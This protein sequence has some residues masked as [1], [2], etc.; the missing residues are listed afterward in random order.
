[1]IYC[2]S[3]FNYYWTE[4]YILSYFL[5]SIFYLF[6]MTPSI[7]YVITTHCPCPHGFSHT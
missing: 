2:I 4:E 5:E 7:D 6:S 1:M 3:F